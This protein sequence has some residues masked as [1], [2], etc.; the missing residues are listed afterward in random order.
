MYYETLSPE[1][2]ETLDQLMVY[3]DED[4]ETLPKHL[5]MATVSKMNLDEKITFIRK[6]RDD[7]EMKGHPLLNEIGQ[8]LAKINKGR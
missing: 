1:H 2:Q 3:L 4:M 8:L 6:L 5:Q 7:P